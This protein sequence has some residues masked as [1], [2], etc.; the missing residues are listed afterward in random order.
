[1]DA[2]FEVMMKA[3][4]EDIACRREGMKAA[5]RVCELRGDYPQYTQDDFEG[6]ASEARVIET[7]VH[8]NG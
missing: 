2:R 6:L 3:E 8:Q 1:M 4:L 7:A 5:N